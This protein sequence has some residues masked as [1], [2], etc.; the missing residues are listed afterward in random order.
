MTLK[1]ERNMTYYNNKKLY[2][3]T[4]NHHF[5]IFNS[6]SMAYQNKL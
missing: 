5:E 1:G 2:T 6:F 3:N 4:Q